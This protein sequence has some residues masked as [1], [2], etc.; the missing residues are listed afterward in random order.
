MSRIEGEF[1]TL[2]LEIGLAEAI[3]EAIRGVDRA[4]AEFPP[5]PPT[6]YLQRLAEQRAALRDPS[7][8]TS[9]ALV[10][11]L[12]ERRPDLTATIQPAFA[13]L[14]E[15]YPDLGWFYAQLPSGDGQASRRAG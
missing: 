14:V 4:I 2:A 5:G 11:A 7:L 6:R 10:V 15:V 9:V 3:L 13:R 1:L 8:R 12:C